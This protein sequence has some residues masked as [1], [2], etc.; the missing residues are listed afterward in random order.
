MT[1]MK[2]DDQYDYIAR[3]KCGCGAVVIAIMDDPD[4][5]KWTAEEVADT[6]KRGYNVDRISAAQLRSL[7]FGCQRERQKRAAPG[8]EQL[9]IL[10]K[11]EKP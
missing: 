10:G 7:P 5:P 11:E 6:V 1:E 3:C 9:S 2:P 4:D 8:G